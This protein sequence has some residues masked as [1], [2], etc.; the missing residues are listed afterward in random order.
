MC[1]AFLCEGVIVATLIEMSEICKNQLLLTI[2]PKRIVILH[3]H[4][5][6]LHWI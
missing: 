3:F 2:S 5:N 1:I 6:T 4:E